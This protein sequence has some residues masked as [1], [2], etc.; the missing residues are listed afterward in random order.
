MKITRLHN[1][2]LSIII[3][4]ILFIGCANSKYP[5]DSRPKEKADQRLLGKWKEMKDKNHQET[6][7]E[8]ID[9]TVVKKDDHEYQ[10]T[11]RLTGKKGNEKEKYTAFLSKIDEAT[12]LNIAVKDEKKADGYFIVR[13]LD[14]NKD[15]N[16]LA[17][18][19]IADT[20]MVYLNS[21]AA[22][23]ERIA[24]NLNNPAFYKDTGYLYKVK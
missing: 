2:L 18:S 17:V 3:A 12:F 4:S 5:I 15:A 19:T 1:V 9:Y 24:K 21:A 20:T 8:D 14:I 16:E 6:N 22:V 10:I 11:M 7:D 23:R 13:V